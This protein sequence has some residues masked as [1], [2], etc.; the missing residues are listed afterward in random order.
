VTTDI[1]ACPGCG[2]ELPVSEW[3]LDRAV[4]ATPACWHLC[5][6]VIANEMQNARDPGR[7]H[8]LT[9]DA[10]GAQH[11]GEPTPRISTAFSLIGL[12]LALDEGW[13]GTAVRAAHQYLA[14]VRREWPGFAPPESRRG[15]T[16]ADVASA[17]NPEQ[18]AERVQAWAASAWGAWR[19]DHDRVRA[20]SAE[21]LP[22]EVR[23]RLRSA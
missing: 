6:E 21:V 16:I 12:H 4:N 5:T 13:T 3:P 7:L 18:Q 15:L 20:W 1:T 17:A 11:A 23:G 9:V 2:L 19:A 22:A 8:Q 14:Q 10:Y